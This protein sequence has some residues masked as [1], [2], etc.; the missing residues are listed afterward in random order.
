MVID[1]YHIQHDTIL[2]HHPIF[3]NPNIVSKS[4][5]DINY[6][7][8]Y[9]QAIILLRAHHSCQKLINYIRSYNVLTPIYI[10]GKTYPLPDGANGAIYYSD[11]SISFLKSTINSF[12]QRYV[13]SMVFNKDLSKRTQLLN[14]AN[15]LAN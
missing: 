7:P 8:H 5:R 2:R 6:Q 12:P 4:I 10:L 13:W 1:V 9:K 11:L 3:N 15:C 14:H